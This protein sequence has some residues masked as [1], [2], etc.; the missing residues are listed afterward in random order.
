M[1]DTENTDSGSVSEEVKAAL[2]EEVEFLTD[3]F[4]AG[5]VSSHRLWRGELSIGIDKSILRDAVQA[6]RDEFSPSYNY[7][8][9]VTA[10]H[11]IEWDPPVMDIIYQFRALPGSGKELRLVV[12]VPDEG[13][14]EVDSIAEM[15]PGSD[16]HEREVYDL[17]GVI[18][19]GHPDLR[20]ILTPETY[21]E[22]PLRRDFPGQGKELMEFH[23]RLIAQ[24]NVSDDERDYDGK[25]G[26]PWVNRVQQQYVGDVS[27]RRLAS[28]LGYE[29]EVQE[30]GDVGYQSYE[31][32]TLHPDDEKKEGEN[33]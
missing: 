32:E 31:K 14:I 18:F 29:G 3:K 11:W 13:T 33:S 21:P 27:L 1:V 24:W 12:R 19:K 4:G 5:K 25:F 20:R 7:I 26:D 9:Y 17:F 30:P 10:D 22:H 15:H 8:S 28:S 2:P 16:W 6:L 23:D